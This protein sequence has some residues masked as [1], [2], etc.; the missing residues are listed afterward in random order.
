MSFDTLAVV[1]LCCFVQHIA[2]G[3]PLSPCRSTHWRWAHLPSTA[4][5]HRGLSQLSVEAALRVIVGPFM[6]W[7]SPPCRPSVLRVV[8]GVFVLGLGPVALSLDPPCRPSGP[9][10]LSFGPS[11]FWAVRLV[12][13]AF[14]LSLGLFVLSFSVVLGPLFGVTSF[15]GGNVASAVSE[16]VHDVSLASSSWR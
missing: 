12:I 6:L 10:V 1:S 8:V 3:F 14:A 13:G 2:S 5:H 7:M 11:Y 9:F 4:S 15:S 16:P